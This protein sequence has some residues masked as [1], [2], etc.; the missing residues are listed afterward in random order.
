MSY[1]RMVAQ[2]R[3]EVPGGF[4]IV[5]SDPC[6]THPVSPVRHKLRGGGVGR[7][8]TQVSEANDDRKERGELEL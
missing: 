4:H 2:H 8:P 5:P 3:V 6:L 7:L 1:D